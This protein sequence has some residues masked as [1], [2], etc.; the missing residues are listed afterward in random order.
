LTSEK[1][2]HLMV[3]FGYSWFLFFFFASISLLP[4]AFNS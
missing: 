3:C 2:T 1:E 4:F